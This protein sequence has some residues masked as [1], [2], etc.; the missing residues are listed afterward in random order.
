MQIYVR[1]H[2]WISFYIRDLQFLVSSFPNPQPQLALPRIYH[3]SFVIN[4][5]TIIVA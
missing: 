4:K 1:L 5:P 3:S 2:T